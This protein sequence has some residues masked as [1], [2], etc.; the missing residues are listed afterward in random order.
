RE[1]PILKLID[2]M[3]DK[4]NYEIK[5]Y[6]P[7]VKEY[8][9][10]VDNVIK[11]STDSDLIVLAV[12]HSIFRNLPLNDMGKVMRNKNLFDTRNFFDQYEIEEKGFRYELLGEK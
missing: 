1:S 7:H 6:D 8:K 10:K 5:V 9:Y 11:A 4:E 12:N 3:E 2:L